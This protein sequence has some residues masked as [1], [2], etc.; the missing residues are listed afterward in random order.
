MQFF[1]KILDLETQEEIEIY[2]L[3]PQI[4][5][6]LQETGVQNGQFFVFS[7]HTT[8]ALAINDYEVRLLEDIKV[9]LQIFRLGWSEKTYGFVTNLW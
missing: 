3:T 5:Q 2:N 7:R 1:H 4:H 9:Y 6:Y 8:T